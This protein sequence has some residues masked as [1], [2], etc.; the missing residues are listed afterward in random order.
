MLNTFN[1]PWYV[2]ILLCDDGSLYTGITINVQ[3]RF[4]AHKTGKGAK[5]TKSRGAKQIL[6][7]QEYPDRHEAA[8]REIEIKQLSHNQKIEITIDNTSCS[9]Q[10]KI[11]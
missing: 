2:Y 9:F 11:N 4:N 7:F 3:K 8:K 5:Y 10:S 1:K 6:Y